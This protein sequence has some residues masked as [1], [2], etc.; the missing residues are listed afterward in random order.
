MTLRSIV[1][2]AAVATLAFLGCVPVPA[3]AQMTT[4]RIAGARFEALAKP[5]IAGIHPPGDAVLQQAYPIPDQVVPLGTVSLQAGS[6]LVNPAFVNVPVTIDVDGHFVRQVF[7]GYKVL[8]YV[9]TAVAAVDL[10]PGTVLG[11][12]DIKMARVLS[13]G[14]RTNGIEA[15][16][17]RRILA[18]IR[19]GAPISIE[20]TQTNQIVK[21]GSTIVLIVHDGGVDV[22]ADVVARMGGGL[23]DEIPVYNPQTNK[24]LSGTITGPDRVELNL[25]GGAQ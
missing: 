2:A 14:Q 6:A 13:Y 22:V 11:Y 12:A 7:I 3:C 25:S 23:G 24:A 1:T 15:L 8:T 9:R 5:M 17:G 16:I 4:Q 18:P 10:D 21:A 20:A 19:A